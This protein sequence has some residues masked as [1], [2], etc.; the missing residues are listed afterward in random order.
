MEED[1]LCTITYGNISSN[2]LRQIEDMVLESRAEWPLA[3]PAITIEYHRTF[4]IDKVGDKRLLG[5]N[6]NQSAEDGEP[7]TSLLGSD[8]A[9][10]GIV[11]APDYSS[12]FDYPLPVTPAQLLIPASKCFNCERPGHS[13]YDCPRPR[14]NATINYNRRKHNESKPVSDKEDTRYFEENPHSYTPGVLSP[15]LKQ[16]LGMGPRD[17]SP[18]FPRMQR[19]GFPP[20]YIG[21]SLT[22]ASNLVFFDDEGVNQNKEEKVLG[23]NQEEVDMDI[24]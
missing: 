3:D 8:G 13:L 12:V 21:A 24:E 14:D 4:C 22:P 19:Y 5:R 1:F 23:S 16:A 18:I 7:N 20:G 2:R 15:R 10:N 6:Y 9:D 11:E 17:I